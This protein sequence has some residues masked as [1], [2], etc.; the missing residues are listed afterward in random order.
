M[1]RQ[2]VPQSMAALGAAGFAAVPA[3]G[4]ELSDRTRRLLRGNLVLDMTGANSPIHPVTRAPANFEPWITK[5]KEAEVTWLSMTTC[6]DF[7]KNTGEMFH[8]VSA[9]RR[10]ILERPDEYVFIET[11]DDVKRAKKEGKLGVNFNFQGSNPLEGDHAPVEPLF[12]TEELYNPAPKY[13]FSHIDY[14]AE[15][16][17]PEYIGLGLDHVPGMDEPLPVDNVVPGYTAN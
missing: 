1:N 16:V 14:M 3:S 5:Y 11:L 8:L 2:Q 9:L 13:I 17:G 10:Y 6:S 15:L 4:S 7:T 12:L